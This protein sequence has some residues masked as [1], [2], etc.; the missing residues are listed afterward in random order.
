[1]SVAPCN[2]T[3]SRNLEFAGITGHV[4]P[5]NGVWI[6]LLARV[7]KTIHRYR[8]FEPG[9]CAGVAVSGGADSVCLLH[10]LLELAPQWG[11]TLCVL[12][13]NHGLRGQESRRDEEFVRDLAARLGLAV[14]VRAV[15]VAAA[16]DNLEQAARHARLAFFRDQLAAG[17][18]S[19]V[20]LGHTRSDQAETVLFR[21]L[22]GSGSAGLAG[23]RPATDD[24][25]VRP[26]LEEDRAQVEQYLRQRGIAWRED[27]SNA[28]LQFARNRIRHHL[29]PQLER[30]WN[31]A[32]RHTL[33]QTADWAQAEE[34]YWDAEIHRLAPSHLAERDGAVI[35]TADSLRGL[36]L[37]A[38][39]RLV[40]HALDRTRGDL[41]G[42]DFGHIAA[43]LKLAS[44]PEGH[45][46]VQAPGVEVIRSFGWLRFSRPGANRGPVAGYCLAASVPGIVRVPGTDIAISLEL[47]EKA[48]TIEPIDCVYNGETGFIDWRILSGALEIR[49]WRPGDQYQPM[50]STGEEKI[51]TLFQ[52]ARI[53]LWERRQ[54]PVITDG[55]AIVWT[56]R[57]GPA[58][59]FVARPGCAA[60]LQIREAAS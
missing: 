3:G 4:P 6:M 18:V 35:A 30:D 41:R 10:V 38:A 17:S 58:E 11:L 33:S 52:K 51:K 45:G 7:A 13:L 39:R 20:A 16:P 44:I 31:P 27:S 21:F 42:V 57:F 36:P 12:H 47:I 14:T 53:P 55:P 26:L 50:G 19:R 29:L 56:R 43:I 46:R 34:E 54:W 48:E 40:R 37:A 28:S 1:M 5:Y 59:R 24:G 22:R 60:M 2:N 25:L 49:N 9:Q 23:I 15:D 32:I 8:M